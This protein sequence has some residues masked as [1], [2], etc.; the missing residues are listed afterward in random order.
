MRRALKYT[1]PIGASLK[2]GT[3]SQA[4]SCVV[5]SAMSPDTDRPEFT[6]L[7]VLHHN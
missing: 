3:D 6:T 7:V 2:R 1:L 5:L 4:Q